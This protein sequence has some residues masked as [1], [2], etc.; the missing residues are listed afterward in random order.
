LCS[1][2]AL[3]DAKPSLSDS[4]RPIISSQTSIVL[5][6]NGVGAEEPLHEAF[7]QNTIISAVVSL[8]PKNPASQRNN[9][10]EPRSHPQVW[11]GGKVIS[12]GVVQQFNREA[13]TIG[14]DWTESNEKSVEKERLDRLVKA[15]E[16]GKGD[17]TVVEDIQSERWVKVIW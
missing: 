16:A 9:S 3:L 15:L 4:I 8:I 2:K 13:I 5:F 11:T 1:N 6:Q 10:S 7:P 14:V 12:N 17:C